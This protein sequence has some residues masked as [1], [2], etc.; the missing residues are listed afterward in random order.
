MNQSV[1]I[2]SEEGSTRLTFSEFSRDADGTEHCK[3]SVIGATC[4]GSASFRFHP[5]ES[6]LVEFFR[7]AVSSPPVYRTDRYW[8]DHQQAVHF[9]IGRRDESHLG[10][11]AYLRGED[12]RWRLEATIVLK[13]EEVACLGDDLSDLF[14]YENAD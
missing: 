4:Q 11:T 5:G 12:S 10:V 3:V 6:S 14:G 7:S 2:Q 1:T 8:G 13:P 9:C